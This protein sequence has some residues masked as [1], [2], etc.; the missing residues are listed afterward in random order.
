MHYKLLSKKARILIY[1][2]IHLSERVTIQLVDSLSEIEIIIILQLIEARSELD[3]LEEFLTHPLISG[4][5]NRWGAFFAALPQ[6]IN[7]KTS[8]EA[9]QKQLVSIL[10]PDASYL[11]L[12]AALLRSS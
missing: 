9:F 10:H 2:Q 3:S 6:L 8:V 1:C 5:M 12:E 7:P 4:N 11:N